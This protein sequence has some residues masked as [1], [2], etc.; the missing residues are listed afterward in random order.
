VDSGAQKRDAVLCQACL[1]S[2]WLAFS[3][4]GVMGAGEASTRSEASTRAP[5][6]GVMHLLRDAQGANCMGICNAVN[7]DC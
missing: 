7:A 1:G 2:G 5:V 4:G 3:G 6:L